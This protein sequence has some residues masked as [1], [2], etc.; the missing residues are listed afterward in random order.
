[1]SGSAIAEKRFEPLSKIRNSRTYKGKITEIAINRPGEVLVRVAG[2][3]YIPLPAK[4]TAF[5]TETWCEELC[6]FLAAASNLRWEKSY[7]I[8][9]VRTPDGDRFQAQVGPNVVSGISVSI[10]VKRMMQAS[11]EDFEVTAEQRHIIERSLETGGAVLIS[12]GTGTG[13]TTFLDLLTRNLPATERIISVE[14]VNEIT[15]PKHPN[16]SQLI[17]SRGGSMTRIGWTDQIDCALRSN[18]DRII[19]GELAIPS[20]FA[21]LQ[22]MDTGHEGTMTTMHANSPMDALRGFHRRINLG[23]GTGGDFGDLLD[24]FAENVGA[25]VQIKHKS[26]GGNTERRYVSEVV[27]AKNLV[28]KDARQHERDWQGHWSKTIDLGLVRELLL[29]STGSEELGDFDRQFLRCL[30]VLQHASLAM[31]APTALEKDVP[32][33]ASPEEAMLMHRAASHGMDVVNNA[34]DQ[35]RLNGI[36]KRWEHDRTTARA[37][38]AERANA[39]AAVG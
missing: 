8:L 26:T 36:L 27:S 38:R 7:P 35:D 2:K 11:W 3:G 29:V 9:A 20:A 21:T 12:G 34:A 14:D 25:I 5:V 10:R 28:T 22:V 18:P 31:A 16:N 1:M 30:S 24:F 17:V 33:S 32:F 6:Q 19:A 23:G 15:L 4:D 39:A 37:E 13:K